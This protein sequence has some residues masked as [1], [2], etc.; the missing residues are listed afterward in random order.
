[1]PQS[2]LLEI[3]FPTTAFNTHS[4]LMS[5]VD[6]SYSETRVPKVSRSLWHLDPQSHSSSSVLI[7]PTLTF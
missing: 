3:R 4:Q 7:I 1:M 2:L 6:V 5:T